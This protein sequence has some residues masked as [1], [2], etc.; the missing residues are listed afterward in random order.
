MTDLERLALLP[1]GLRDDLPDAAAF[2]A[3]VIE[4]LM[5]YFAR[6]GYER[7]KP[8]LVE[9]EDSLLSGTGASLAPQT[10]RLMD[11]VSQR[12]MAVRAD[13]TPQIARIAQSRLANAPR[14]LRLS[15]SGEV[16]RVRGSQLRADRQFVQVG[17]ELIGVTPAAVID[18]D[19]EIM[20]MA[21][22]AL[23]TYGV[24][25]L[26]ID[27]ALPT[28]VPVLAGELGLDAAA[29]QIAREAL[30]HKDAPALGLLPAAAAELMRGLLAATGK[31]EPAVEVLAKLSLPPRSAALAREA[32]SLVTTIRTA[33]PADNVALTL[34]PGEYRGFEYQTGIS[35][36]LFAKGI[37]GELGRGGRYM[38]ISG[39]HATGFTI[40]MDTLLRAL[41]EPKR[42]MRIYL[43]PGTGAAEA[44]GLRHQDWETVAGLGPAP[45]DP[46]KE[47]R[48]LGCSHVLIAGKPTAL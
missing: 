18:A 4:S 19:A 3:R 48:R 46:A 11:P 14:P 43:P 12:M 6:Y 45:A 17:A 30:D 9:F 34:D 2:E 39:E 47:A 37:R 13:I 5:G 44:E 32:H 38:L 10:F 1:E 16:L 22:L 42:R 24:K 36:T 33:W 29:T 40:Y 41:P 28:L 7:V 23:G 20:L 35:F 21:A 25:G 26:S 27:L 31:A 15:Y 8:P